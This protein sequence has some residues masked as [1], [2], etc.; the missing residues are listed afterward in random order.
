MYTHTIMINIGISQQRERAWFG[1]ADHMHETTHE[2]LESHQIVSGSTFF[3]LVSTTRRNTMIIN[4]S[5]YMY[6]I[7]QVVK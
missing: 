7:A 6:Y 1:I 2:I 5:I 4:I 3:T